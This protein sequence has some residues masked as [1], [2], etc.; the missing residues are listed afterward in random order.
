MLIGT[1]EVVKEPQEKVRA[2]LACPCPYRSIK[3]CLRACV[4]M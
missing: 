2:C 1:A 4:P 3:T